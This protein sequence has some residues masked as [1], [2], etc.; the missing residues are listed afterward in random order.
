VLT[1]GV[2]GKLVRNSLIMYDRETH[3]FWSHLTGAAIEGPLKGSQLQVVAATQ[4]SWQQWRQ[5]QPGTQVLPHDYPGQRDSY[6]GYFSGGDAGI[7]G[8]KRTDARLPTKAKIVGVRVTD[9]AKA[10]SLGAVVKARV[11]N[12]VFQEVPLAVFGAAPETARVYRR[13]LPDR[14]LTFSAAPGGKVS[15]QETGSTWDPLT[16][17]ATAGALVGTSLIPMTVTYSF[18]FGWVDFFPGTALY[19]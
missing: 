10:Y 6:R 15:D 12:D 16:G 7:L 9:H 11:V 17:K 3:T 13:D 8:P 14:T 19:P 2:S 5:A 18:W 1:F 4:T